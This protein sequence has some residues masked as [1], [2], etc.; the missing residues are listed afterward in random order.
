MSKNE[1][2]NIE[3]VENGF[4]VRPRPFENCAISNASIFVFQTFSEL[5]SWLEEHFDHRNTD[6]SNDA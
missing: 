5:S 3:Q 1:S 2:I 4:I 6:I